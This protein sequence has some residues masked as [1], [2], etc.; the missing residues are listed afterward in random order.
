MSMRRTRKGRAVLLGTALALALVGCG[1]ASSDGDATTGETQAQERIVVDS[2]AGDSATGDGGSVGQQVMATA[3][4]T[5]TGVID[6]TDLFTTRDLEQVADTSGATA[7]ALADGQDVQIAQE[8]V[9]VVSGTARNATITVDVDSTEKVQIVLDGASITNDDFPCIYVVSADKVFV[10]TTEGSHN[11]LEVTGAF[12]ADGETNTDAV[13][14]SRDDLVLNGLGTLVVTSSDNGI[15]SKDDLKVTGGTYEVTAASDA[16]EANDSIAIADGTISVSTSKDGLHAEDDEDDTTGYIYICGGT[17]GIDAGSDGI[18]ATTYLQIDGGSVTVVAGEGLESTYVQV[19]GG[20]IDLTASDDGINATNKSSSVGTPTIDIRG[21]S[22]TVTMGAGDTDAL[23][24]N[25]NLYIS[26][27]TVNISAQFAFDYDGEGV[28]SGGEV[29]VNGEQV[30][31]IA[32]SMM[33][34]GMGG[35]GGDMGGGPMMGGGP[36]GGMGG[37]GNWG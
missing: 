23:D 9:Y 3:N 18:Q 1:T 5:S 8:G 17:L 16:L 25:G 7:I 6:A 32:E 37:P 30:S 12:V 24:A 26:G 4:V 21:G 27:G 29:Y 31:E 14:F 15:S 20:T 19:N 36:G 13:I 11:S 35:P 34:G 10:T 28:L 22:I 2:T 33:M